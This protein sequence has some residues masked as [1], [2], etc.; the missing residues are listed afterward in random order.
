M[1]SAALVAHRHRPGS[2]DGGNRNEPFASRRLRRP[3][4]LKSLIPAQLRRIG[5]CHGQSNAID[6]ARRINNICSED[7]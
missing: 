5:I 2:T 6:N 3:E 1:G 4:R 7:I